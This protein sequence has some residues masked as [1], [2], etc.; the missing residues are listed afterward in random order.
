MGEWPQQRLLLPPTHERNFDLDKKARHRI[1]S[2]CRFLMTY[3]DTD[4][5]RELAQKHGFAVKA[6]AM[7]NTHHAKML[8]LLISRDLDWLRF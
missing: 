6:V 8:E 1:R 7:K 2:D 3:D 4:E 5:V